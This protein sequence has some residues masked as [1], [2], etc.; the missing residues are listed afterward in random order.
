MRVAELYAKK[1]IGGKGPLFV[2]I[3]RANQYPG[4]SHIYDRNIE[5][6]LCGQK[7]IWAVDTILTIG[8]ARKRKWKR[9]NPCLI[10][11]RK[12]SQI[13]REWREIMEMGLNT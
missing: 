11:Y 7:A 6:T 8:E 9:M 4:C 10:C 1:F 5:K 13:N 12:I 3:R 2:L